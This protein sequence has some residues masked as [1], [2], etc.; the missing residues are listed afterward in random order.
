MIS[1][2]AETTRTAVDTEDDPVANEIPMSHSRWPSSAPP[3][4][5]TTADLTGSASEINHVAGEAVEALLQCL[6]QR[7]MGV[8][9]SGEFVDG[10]I[11]LLRER[12]LG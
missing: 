8:N 6:R 2:A 7:R 3:T 10:Q 1:R 11:P 9:V 12:Q 4:P 5:A